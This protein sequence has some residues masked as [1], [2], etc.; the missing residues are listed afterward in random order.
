MLDQ[1]SLDL[2]REPLSEADLA[3]YCGRYCHVAAYQTLLAA[4]TDT[5]SVVL[6][7]AEGV[8]KGALIRRLQQESPPGIRFLECR[9]TPA[10]LHELLGFLCERLGLRADQELASR[11]RVVAD[12]LQQCRSQG[13]RLVVIL[14]Q[15]EQLNS[16]LLGDLLEGLARDNDYLPQLLLSG[17]GRLAERLLWIHSLD[18]RNLIH[19]HL[20]RLNDAETR[21]LLRWSL[22][23]LGV[24][25][26][27]L[28]A[29]ALDSLVAQAQGLPGR[30][31]ALCEYTS[32]LAELEVGEEITGALLAGASGELE[33]LDDDDEDLSLRLDDLLL[34]ESLAVPDAP[35]PTLTASPQPCI[36][37]LDGEDL[38]PEPAPP[39]VSPVVRRGRFGGLRRRPLLAASVTALLGSLAAYG[40]YQQ[41]LG[42]RLPPA[43]PVQVLTEL[44]ASSPLLAVPTELAR[45]LA[46]DP[47][48]PALPVVAPAHGQATVLPA[49]ELVDAVTAPATTARQATVPSLDGRSAPV[50]V[51]TARAVVDTMEIPLQELPPVTVTARDVV[52]PDD[53]PVPVVEAAPSVAAIP[54]WVDRLPALT[55]DLNR[56][57]DRLLASL[58]SAPAPVPARS[59][60]TPEPASVPA[61][62]EPVAAPPRGRPAT[63]VELHAGGDRHLARNDPATARLFYESAAMDG[64]PR[65][66]LAVAMTYD[67]VTL[68]AQGLRWSHADPDLATE[69]YLYAIQQGA[70]EAEAQLTALSDW[71]AAQPRPVPTGHG[72]P[73]ETPLANFRLNVVVP[74]RTQFL[75]GGDR[76][77]QQSDPAAARLLYRAAAEAGST[78]AMVAVAMTYDP[79]ELASRGF[80]GS[81]GDP[82]QALAW[83]RRARDLGAV[84]VEARIDRLARG[85]TAS[86]T[87]LS[88]RP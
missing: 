4:I 71:L 29:D 28:G 8:G 63:V 19:C 81:H 10:D 5:T 12:Y 51:E 44:P 79:L 30:V 66:A 85:Q 72:L 69:W 54:A 45:P 82:A 76:W 24:D 56:W 70:G 88:R 75:R 31:V 83:Y 48:A 34:T 35:T 64:D 67:P 20:T 68:T 87:L 60:G 40:L 74:S 47:A 78:V 65:A 62:I 15:A 77:L 38:D 3:L 58:A 52:T 49:T 9:S 53:A 73:A 84:G 16:S 18:T 25:S 59:I 41:V 43:V 26:D 2:E 1:V 46:A 32:T 27:R 61:S 13:S 55:A 42:P 39:A 17:A 80:I 21:D 11:E 36:D 6:T 14:Q 37:L 57:S 23:Y 7:G 33:L 86:P 50:S 22:S